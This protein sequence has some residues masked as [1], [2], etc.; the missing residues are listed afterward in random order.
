ML[1][2]ILRAIGIVLLIA[3]VIFILANVG[4]IVWYQGFGKLQ[5]IFSPFNIWNNIMVFLTIAP[6]AFFMWLADKLE[7]RKR[8]QARL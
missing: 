8:M 5:E 4:L 6:G 2:K 7:S 1:I 3:A